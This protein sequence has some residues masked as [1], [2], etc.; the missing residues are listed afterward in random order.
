MA[1]AYRFLC[2]EFR[3]SIYPLNAII[4]E[5]YGAGKCCSCMPFSFPGQVRFLVCILNQWLQPYV[6]GT[7]PLTLVLQ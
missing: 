4:T 6:T 3:S 5:L 7:E 1:L 2:T